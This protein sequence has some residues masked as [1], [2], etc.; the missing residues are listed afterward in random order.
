MKQFEKV[1]KGIQNVKSGM[2]MVGFLTAIKACAIVY[3]S[4]H[5][6]DELCKGGHGTEVSVSGMSAFLDSEDE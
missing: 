3:C 6:P 5:C 1:Q 4:E 2:E